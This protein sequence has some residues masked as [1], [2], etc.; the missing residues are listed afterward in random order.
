MESAQKS[1]PKG[2]ERKKRALNSPLRS[3][4][5]IATIGRLDIVLGSAYGVARA[6][7]PS[8]QLQQPCCRRRNRTTSS[9]LEGEEET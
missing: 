8:L 1:A 2:K 9:N 7:N 4:L 6:S 3:P 5:D